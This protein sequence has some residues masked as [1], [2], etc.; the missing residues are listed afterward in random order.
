MIH[1][2]TVSDIVLPKPTEYKYGVVHYSKKSLPS[3]PVSNQSLHFGWFR[4]LSTNLLLKYRSTKRIHADAVSFLLGPLRL[5]A[6]SQSMTSV[7]PR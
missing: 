7:H 2:R 1:L 3:Y 5:Y 4:K 6:Y